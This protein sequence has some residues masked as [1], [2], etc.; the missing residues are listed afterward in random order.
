MA[1]S[2]N[3]DH[4]DVHFTKGPCRIILKLGDLL[5]ETGVDAIVIP[6]PEGAESSD[7][8]YPVFK[9][10]YDSADERLTNQI[11]HSGAKIKQGGPP[12][13]ITDAKPYVILTPIPYLGNKKKTLAMLAKTYSACLDHRRSEQVPQHRFSYYGMW[14]QWLFP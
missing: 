5:K 4:P 14:E 8:N 3:H 10:M 7:G 13:I 1:E 2:V 12:Q 6:T 11:E 9:A